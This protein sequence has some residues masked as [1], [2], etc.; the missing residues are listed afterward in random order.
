MAIE[1]FDPRFRVAGDDVDICWRLEE[2]GWTI[3]FAAAAVVWHHRRNSLKAYF[4]Q[5]RGY[6]EAEALLADKWPSKYNR[7]GH[8][9]WQGRLYGRG[10]VGS[11]FAR[12]RI[13]HGVWGSASFQSLYEPCSG[14]LCSLMLVPEWYFVL[15]LLGLLS[16]FRYLMD[17]ASLGVSIARYRHVAIGDPGDSS[18]EASNL[19]PGASLKRAPTRSAY[20][21]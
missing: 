9:T 3:G 18:G 17:A 10:V 16:V 4:K 6:A 19:S 15:G 8:L 13:Y 14:N 2:R 5:Q 20:T 12:S 21:G 1:G 11:L 7:A